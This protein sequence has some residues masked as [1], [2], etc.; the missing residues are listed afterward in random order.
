MTT[1]LLRRCSGESVYEI[2]VRKSEL[3][4]LDRMREFRK[5]CRRGGLFVTWDGHRIWVNVE[6]AAQSSVLDSSG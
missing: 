3:Y 1:R 5:R 4:L 2:Q 6:P